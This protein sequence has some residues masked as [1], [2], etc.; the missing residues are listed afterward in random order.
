M[1]KV[2]TGSPSSVRFSELA[3]DR[4]VGG[5]LDGRAVAGVPH[6]LV[7]LVDPVA[8][9]AVAAAQRAHVLVARVDVVPVEGEVVHEERVRGPGRSLTSSM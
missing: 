5:L 9:A 2:V 4:A 8:G 3:V 7:A 1:A 6:E